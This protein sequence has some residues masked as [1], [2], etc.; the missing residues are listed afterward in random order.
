[1]I[2][3]FLGNK[4][5]GSSASINYLLN[6]KRVQDGTARILKGDES[7]TR[8][9]IDALTKKQKVTFGV[10]SFEEENIP[11]HEKKELM[12]EFEKTFFAG[13]E[14]E[15][16]NILWV[17]HTDKGRLELNCIIPK[18]ELSTGRS[19]NAYNH[20]TDFHL[21]D[22]F[23]TKVN[24]QYEYSDPKDPSKSQ[25]V[26]GEYKKTGVIKDYEQLDKLL[27]NLVE[28]NVIT[29]RA[30]IVGFLRDNDIEVTR[31][32]KNFISIKLEK[33]HKAKR[34]KGSIY[35]EQFGEIKELEIISREQETKEREYANRDTR[36]ELERVSQR[37]SKALQ[38]RSIYNQQFYSKPKQNHRVKVLSMDSSSIN[39]RGR[40]D[41]LSD[42]KNTILSSAE[43]METRED[44]RRNTVSNQGELNDRTRENITRGIAIREATLAKIIKASRNDR[45]E[46]HNGAQRDNE[47]LYVKAQGVM[48]EQRRRRTARESISEAIRGLTEK[49]YS[50]GEFLTDK[51]RGSIRESKDLIQCH[52]EQLEEQEQEQNQGMRI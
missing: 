19:L 13:L 15:Q 2:L 32:S 8:K 23:Q 21:A 47:Q 25:T 41:S 9:I 44:G 7:K 46:I 11:E 29:S 52:Q 3:K 24:L 14:Q 50:F 42:T 1:M 48:Q 17:E 31:E 5:G 40:C 43:N 33:H 22:M 38:K 4:K 10:L 37:L 49:I 28:E 30:E 18:V 16:Y 39:V 51:I 36:K 27:H 12:Q 35:N 20:G 34:L 26:Q 45:E 6:N